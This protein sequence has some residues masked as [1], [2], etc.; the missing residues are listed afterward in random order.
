MLSEGQKNYPMCLGWI[1]QKIHTKGNYSLTSNEA[2]LLNAPISKK[3]LQNLQ[4]NSHTNGDWKLLNG[5]D[6]DIMKKYMEGRGRYM[7]YPKQ[8]KGSTL[9]TQIAILEMAC[10]P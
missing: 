8:Y 3:I 7:Q 1:T 6:R 5:T 2:K 4:S 10:I 9:K